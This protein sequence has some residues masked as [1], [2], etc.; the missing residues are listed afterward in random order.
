MAF[1][2]QQI[3]FNISKEGLRKVLDATEG[4][5]INISVGVDNNWRYRI[6]ASPY[7]LNTLQRGEEPSSADIVIGCPNPPGCPPRGEN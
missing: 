6:A 2:H 7:A 5:E 4:E 1:F 3:N